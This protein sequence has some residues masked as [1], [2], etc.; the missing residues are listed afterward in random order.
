MPMIR[1]FRTNTLL[2]TITLSIAAASADG[3]A[4]ALLSAGRM[5]DAIR[6]LNSQIAADPNNAEA[7]TLL[8]RA[9]YSLGDFETAIK[10]G[11]KAVQLK[12]GNSSY[13][14]ELGKAY[15]DKADSVGAFSAIGPAKK[16]RSE[17]ERALQLDPNNRKARLALTEFY[18]E[19]PGI[20]G[21]G[22]DKAR[23]LAD[24]IATS[25]PAT[26]SWI[27]AIVANKEKKWA[28]AEKEFRNSI[29]ASGSAASAWIDLAR[30]YAWSKRWND[31]E[32]AMSTALTSGKKRPGDLFTAAELL[33]GTNRNYPAA[34]QALRT[35][36]DGGAKDEEGPAF[37]AHFL[38]GQLYD[39]Q[40]NKTGAAK[41][42]RAALALAQGFKPAQDALKRLGS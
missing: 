42:Y 5:D 39:K 40:G 28:E 22:K 1:F 14:Y 12:P 11:E 34:E 27:R 32:S 18:V 8:S 23:K 20:M 3:P 36:I 6:T 2:L 26:A 29:A 4:S 24:E 16:A 19:A 35:Y 30:F 13:H 25:D 21:G 9:Y 33:I 17:F 10:H 15:G 7:H 38:L 31:F 37:R 41:E